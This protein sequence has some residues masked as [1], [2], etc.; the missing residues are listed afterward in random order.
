MKEPPMICG[1]QLLSPLK[2]LQKPA[3]KQGKTIAEAQAFF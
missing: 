2:L 1:I 3:K